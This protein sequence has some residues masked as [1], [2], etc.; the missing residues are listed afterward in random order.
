MVSSLPTTI[1]RE[2]TAPIALVSL[3]DYQH[4]HKHL[5]LAITSVAETAKKAY[6]AQ[7][8]AHFQAREKP[9]SY[10][11]DT[12]KVGY[13]LALSVNHLKGWK[14]TT[15]SVVGELDDKVYAYIYHNKFIA[16]NGTVITLKYIPTNYKGNSFDMLFIEFSLPKLVLGCNHEDID[17]WQ[18]AFRTANSIIATIPGLPSLPNIR[19][20]VLYR[21]DLCAN[22]QVG[23]EDVSDYIQA[24][25]KGCHPHRTTKPFGKNGVMFTSQKISTCIY[26]KFQECGSVEAKGILR[27]EIS[28]RA[29]REISK[30]IGNAEPTLKNITKGMVRGL[31]IKDMEVL[32]LDTYMVCDRLNAQAILKAKYSRSRVQKL[33]GYLDI[34]R[35]TTIEQMKQDG[36]TAQSIRYHENLLAKA[37]ISSLSIESKE[38]LPALTLLLDEIGS[39]KNYHI[40]PSDT[41]I[42]EFKDVSS[43]NHGVHMDTKV[44]ILPKQ[45]KAQHSN[46]HPRAP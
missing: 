31:L 5:A 25:H 18:G 12:I 16:S 19:D 14:L 36:Y 29:R 41:R 30:W 2:N 13:S 3:G 32:H 43:Y 46:I 38:T 21:I 20:A 45:W 28:M 40:V 37:G 6:G 7:E 10:G 33:L 17:D 4:D 24:L 9:S 42:S 39:E 35:T 1:T 34:R 11:I 27:Y 44:N 23:E 8:L 26:D 22:L 15:H